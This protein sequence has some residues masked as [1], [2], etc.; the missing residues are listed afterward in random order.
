M[1]WCETRCETGDQAFFTQQPQP[2]LSFGQEPASLHCLI[3]ELPATRHTTKLVIPWRRCLPTPKPWISK[4]SLEQFL[5]L[6]LGFLH[7]FAIGLV[8]R[9]KAYQ[10]LSLKFLQLELSFGAAR[11]ITRSNPNA[12]EK[13]WGRNFDLGSKLRTL[14]L[15]GSQLLFQDFNVA[16]PAG[17]FSRLYRYHRDLQDASLPLKIKRLQEPSKEPKQQRPPPDLL[18][19]SQTVGL[20]PPFW[21]GRNEGSF[22]VKMMD[23][24]SMRERGECSGDR[25]GGGGVGRIRRRDRRDTWRVRERRGRLEMSA[26]L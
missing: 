7:G 6:A 16:G 12:M 23:P 4:P 5:T 11:P 2:H 22:G 18:P 3:L 21:G 19:A 8:A 20:C 15:Q 17:H 1:H 26:N 14:L 24:S 13:C 25:V 9:R 10:S